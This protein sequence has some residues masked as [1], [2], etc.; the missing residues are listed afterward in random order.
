VNH[1]CLQSRGH[2]NTPDSLEYHLVP[3]AL[4]F[5]VDIQSGAHCVPGVLL[6]VELCWG[7]TIPSFEEDLVTDLTASGWAQKLDNTSVFEL[8]AEDHTM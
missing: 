3:A 2:A 1:A 8:T 5:S 6:G 4:A 7:F